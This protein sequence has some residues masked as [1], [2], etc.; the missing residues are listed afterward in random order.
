[1]RLKSCSFVGEIHIQAT[2]AGPTGVKPLPRHIFHNVVDGFALIE[3]VEEG[4]E[5]AEI[6]AGGI[7][8]GEQMRLDAG[9]FVGDG[10]ED[11][12]ARGWSLMPISFSVA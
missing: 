1:M 4:G 10:A 9:E 11:F 8:A 2:D 7:T 12:A 6:E 5:S 3:A